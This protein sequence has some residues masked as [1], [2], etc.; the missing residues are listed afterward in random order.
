VFP[1]PQEGIIKIYAANNVSSAEAGTL[2]WICTLTATLT[3][4]LITV[5]QGFPEH[6]CFI[7]AVYFMWGLHVY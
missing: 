5:T 7:T 1:Q 2:V 4:P 6:A 3:Y